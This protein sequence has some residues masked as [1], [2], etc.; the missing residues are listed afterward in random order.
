MLTSDVSISWLTTP[1]TVLAL[2]LNPLGQNKQN[3]WVIIQRELTSIFYLPH[4]THFKGSSVIFIKA[5]VT[6]RQ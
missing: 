3:H 2:L 1:V 5:N 4:N 6:M